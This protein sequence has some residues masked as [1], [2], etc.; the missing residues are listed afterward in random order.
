M[1]AF[2]SKVGDSA[3][4]KWLLSCDFLF[5]FFTKLSI[6]GFSLTFKCLWCKKISL[7][8]ALFPGYIKHLILPLLCEEKCDSLLRAKKMWFRFPYQ[9]FHIKEE[10]M[11]FIILPTKHSVLK[12]KKCDLDTPRPPKKK[13]FCTKEKRQRKASSFFKSHTL[14]LKK[15]KKQLRRTNVRLF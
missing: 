13:A 7:G 4:K 9:P 5:L 8:Q 12:S 15:K 2:T 1:P 14:F 3:K 11:W 10:K 6:N